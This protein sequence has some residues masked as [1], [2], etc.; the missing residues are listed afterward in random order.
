MP[1]RQG[2]PD[3]VNA[4]RT[5]DRVARREGHGASGCRRHR[6][7]NPLEVQARLF[8]PFFTTKAAQNGTGLGLPMVKDLVQDIGGSVEISSTEG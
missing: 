2:N 3:P 1:C 6:A 7:W 5:Q 8:E 4:H